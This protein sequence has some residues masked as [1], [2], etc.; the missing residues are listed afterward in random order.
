MG[1][2]QLSAFTNPVTP[3]SSHAC[4]HTH[5]HTHTATAGPL[6]KPTT[7]RGEKSKKE[8]KR[9]EKKKSS[10]RMTLFPASPQ[11]IPDTKLS[12]QGHTC[13]H[14]ARGLESTGAHWRAQLLC[15]AWCHMELLALP[16]LL[17]EA[18]G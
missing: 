5:T 7:H 3:G 2:H 9:K 15:D 1:S 6:A 4:T 12:R 13:V 8:K 10:Q 17:G 18:L 16:A 11:S 14:R